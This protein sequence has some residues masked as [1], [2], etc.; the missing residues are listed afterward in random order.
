MADLDMPLLDHPLLSSD[1][2]AM[3]ASSE[4][5]RS[6]NISSDVEPLQPGGP[7]S[8]CCAMPAAC[9]PSLGPVTIVVQRMIRVD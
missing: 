6:G 3:K 9:M 2:S 7:Q 5:R 4:A 8:P 1:G